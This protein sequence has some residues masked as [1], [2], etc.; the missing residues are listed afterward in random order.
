MTFTIISKNNEKTFTDKELVNIS[1]KDGFDFKI[2]VNFNCM[3]TIQHDLKTNRCFVLNQFNS[4][5]FLFKGKPIGQK[6]EVNKICK[7]SPFLC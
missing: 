7:I 2:D 4:R 1:S 3:L 6:M 5:R